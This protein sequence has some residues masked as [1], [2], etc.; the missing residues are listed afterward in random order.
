MA[1]Q[2]S[3]G[4]APLASTMG[5]V[6]TAQRLP[7]VRGLLLPA[8]ATERRRRRRRRPEAAAAQFTVH[9]THQGQQGAGGGAS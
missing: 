6:V 7:Y 4:V 5:R 3:P 2:G 1:A 8:G 9:T